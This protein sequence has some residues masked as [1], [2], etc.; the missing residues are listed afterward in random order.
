MSHWFLSEFVDQ[1]VLAMAFTVD[2]LLSSIPNTVLYL[3]KLFAAGINSFTE[4]FLQV[5]WKTRIRQCPHTSSGQRFA[6]HANKVLKILNKYS[7]VSKHIFTDLAKVTR[8]LMFLCACFCVGLA[9]F[10]VK[11]RLYVLLM[12][13]P[14]PLFVA[15]CIFRVLGMLFSVSIRIAWLNFL[16][17]GLEAVE[18]DENFEQTI[19]E[20]EVGYQSLLDRKNNRR[21]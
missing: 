16:W 21:R 14:F 17:R 6:N 9:I 19:K 20:A 4:K 18:E 7:E 15:L 3:R 13:L 10:D 2:I 12:M 8:A 11:V 5:Q 1:T